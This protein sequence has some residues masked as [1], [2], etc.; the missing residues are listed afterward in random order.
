MLMKKRSFPWLL[1]VLA[2]CISRAPG[3]IAGNDATIQHMGEIVV[4]LE[5]EG[6]DLV[7]APFIKEGRAMVPLRGIM[8]ALDAEVQWSRDNGV[9]TIVITRGVRTVQLTIDS[10]A[11][12][13]DGE[14]FR[15]DA[16][17]EIV[18][19]VTFIPLRFVTEAFG[20][21]TRW[22]GQ[23]R[24]IDI[25][26][27]VNIRKITVFPGKLLLQT[28]QTEAL[29]V[30]I[31]L[32]DG[33][34][35]EVSPREV[36]WSSSREDVALVDVG[37][38]EAVGLGEATITAT[39]RGYEVSARVEVDLDLPVEFS[40]EHR[41]LEAVIR[42]ELD[43]PAGPLYRSDLAKLT[44]LEAND[45]RIEHLQE[46]QYC[47]NL[48]ALSLIGN[49]ISDLELLSGLTRLESLE[50][51]HNQIHRLEPLASLQNLRRLAL[52]DNRIQDIDP[53][54]RLENLAWLSLPR[55]EIAEIS[56]LAGLTLLESLDVSENQ[57]S[58]LDIP[59]DMPAL[60]TLLLRNNLVRDL[61]PLSS[62]KSLTAIHAS[63]N[64]IRDISKI[65]DL[66]DLIWLALYD[67][68]VDP[69]GELALKQDI[70]RLEDRGVYVQL[71]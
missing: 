25:S 39:Y 45:A 47:T 57:V 59:W 38:V 58:T 35:K 65:A 71:D 68:E 64:R 46:I 8:E 53:L 20:A 12:K 9:H 2:M 61:A 14:A 36:S 67:N 28:G 23:L 17:P 50:L 33:S 43:I 15:L 51:G 56:G 49:R 29:H 42:K 26:R 21:E 62:L 40:P 18:S 69:A 22:D 63:G 31:E 34:K 11:A 10:L 1:L 19:D 48:R 27:I 6:L 4:Y 44:R 30:E 54:S 7:Q 13:I 24:R 55:N 16:A 41:R 66:P 37:V 52:N 70:W 32:Q 3:A 5:G 60:Q